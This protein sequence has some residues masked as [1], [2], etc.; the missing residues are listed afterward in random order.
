MNV[1][2]LRWVSLF[3]P[4]TPKGKN[5]TL[6]SRNCLQKHSLGGSKTMLE[7]LGA[8]INMT[9]RIRPSMAFI[10]SL[11]RHTVHSDSVSVSPREGNIYQGWFVTLQR[12]WWPCYLL[13]SWQRAGWVNETEGELSIAVWLWTGECES[14]WPLTSLYQPATEP[15]QNGQ[16]AWDSQTSPGWWLLANTGSLSEAVQPCS[17]SL[18]CGHSHFSRG[19]RGFA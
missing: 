7:C 8:C 14:V 3:C 2:H 16:A 17:V 1:A 18:W 9:V 10:Y 13:G 19:E 6:P 4:G 5:K 12:W 11:H 15:L